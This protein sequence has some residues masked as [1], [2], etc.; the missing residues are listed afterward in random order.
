M[1]HVGC[2]VLNN[3]EITDSWNKCDLQESTPIESP[4]LNPQE[5]GAQEKGSDLPRVAEGLAS[6][7]REQRL[8][9][10]PGPS[11]SV[12]KPL[13]CVRMP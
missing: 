13:R 11:P 12:S 6:R 7:W 1:Q 4:H 9:C 10:R 3:S 8:Q 2:Q 5:N